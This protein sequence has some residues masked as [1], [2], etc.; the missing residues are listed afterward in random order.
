M[1][2]EVQLSPNDYDQCRKTFSLTEREWKLAVES[3]RKGGYT[4]NDFAGLDRTSAKHFARGLGRAV[5]QEVVGE[6]DRP[7]IAR[8]VAFLRGP[9]AGGFTIG[10]GWP[11]WD[12][13]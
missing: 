3:S 8:L 6:A 7:V 10:R 13:A 2:L 4:P 1:G 9:G 12:R 11:K 5:E